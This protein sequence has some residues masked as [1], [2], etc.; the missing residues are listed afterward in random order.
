MGRVRGIQGLGLVCGWDGSDCTPLPHPSPVYIFHARTA[1]QQCTQVVADGL[2]SPVREL[3]V[4]QAGQEE[5]GQLH[6]Q[7][8][9]CIL[10]V[11]AT[12]TENKLVGL[13]SNEPHTQALG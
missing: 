12:E 4:V 10:L 5:E 8:L 13:G 3:P 7:H 2:D 11:V 6:M 1:S 9:L